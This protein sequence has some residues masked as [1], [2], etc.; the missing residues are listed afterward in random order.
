MASDLIQVGGL[1]VRRGGFTLDV[2]SWTVAAG[3]VVGVVGPN[4][5]GKTTLL[6]AIAGLRPVGAG[7]VHVFGLDP[8]R[9]PVKVRSRLGFMSDD[10][11]LFEMRAGALLRMLSGYYPTWD[12]GLVETLLA[13]FDVDPRKKVGELSRGQGSRLRLVTAMAFRPAVLVLD[14]PAAGLDLAGRRTLLE[15]VLEV[16]RDE[17]RAVVISSHA[18]PDVA[19]IADRI[20]VLHHGRVVREG[21]TDELVGEGRTLEEALEAWGAA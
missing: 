13:R 6:E 2:P 17:S 9:E 11:A 20:L 3:D 21:P 14:E 4:G 18:L 12:P 7:A 1:L 10:M 19:R 5:A 8:W 15:S 16:V